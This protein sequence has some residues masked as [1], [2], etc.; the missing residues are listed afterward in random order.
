MRRLEAEAIR[1]SLLAASGMLDL[2]MGGSMLHVGNREFIFN[3]TSKDETS[4]ESLRRSVYLP[5]VRNHL[6]DIFHLFDYSD[7]SV[8]NGSRATSTIAP[9]ALFMMNSPLVVRA[10]QQLADQLLGAYE[11]P[12]DRVQQLYRRAWGR[13]AT[14]SEVARA[15]QFVDRQKSLLGDDSNKDGVAERA[16]AV[17][18]QVVLMSNE[19]IYVR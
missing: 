2:A 1:D 4:Y 6:Y 8:V 7:A 15:I 14:D 3:H 16:W 10:A 13:G 17:L 12:G 11:Q 19:F 9:Q 5:V 18:C